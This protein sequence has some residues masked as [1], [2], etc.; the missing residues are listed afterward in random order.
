[1]ANS[2]HGAQKKQVMAVLADL[3]IV[4]LQTG[5]S[6]IPILEVWNKIDLLTHEEAQELGQVCREREDAVAISAVTG[7][8]IEPLLK[9]V[10]LMLTGEAREFE[11]VLPAS[12][13]RRIAWLHAHGEVVSEEEVGDEE[14]SM[15]RLVVRL[16]PKEFGQFR[17]L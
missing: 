2:A 1:M 4:D 9:R 7:E 8:G 13:G 15:R 5:E 6:T 17:S 14:P 10:S 12:D 16:N 3:G 11:L